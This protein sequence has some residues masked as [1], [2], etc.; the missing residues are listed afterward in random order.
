M[1]DTATVI[2]DL[3][4]AADNHLYIKRDDL[5]PYSFGGNKARKDLLFFREIDAGGYDC[6]VTYGSASS[7]HC[8]VTA[9]LAAARGMQC[10]IISPEETEK[11]TFN[12][13]MMRL[14]GAKITVVPVSEVHDA[15]ER[16]LAQLRK[17]GKK[18][19]FIPG[20]GHGNIG[21]Q[22]YVECCEEIR[23]YEKK[24]DL[25]FDYIFLASGTGTTQAG[26]ICGSL[27]AKEARNIVG[28]SIAR[29]NPRG[30]QVV[31]DSV[32]E[33]LQA[34][35]FEADPNT[36]E[37]A[38]VFTDAYTGS[39]YGQANTQIDACIARMMVQHGIAMD[40][41]YTGKAFAGMQAYLAEQQIKKKNILF[42][43]TGGTPLFFDDL[44]MNEG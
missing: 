20:G 15:I 41:T 44:Q 43:H 28:I 32:R 36:I 35:G 5:F 42:L 16:T 37:A 10:C 31:V 13:R 27:M 24:N 14:F 6:V 8:R 11:P 12:G 4:N 22:A 40:R 38:T 2:Q 17:D 19:Y 1:N 33:Y 39:G 30:R 25:F 23:A 34:N 9:N 26:L 3:G 7:N 21:T 29:K 18:P